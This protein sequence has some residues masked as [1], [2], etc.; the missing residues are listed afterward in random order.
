MEYQDKINLLFIAYIFVIV[1]LF[2][3]QLFIDHI[4]L[5]T[6]KLLQLMIELK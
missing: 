6:I 5:D 4:M 3:L 1:I 2:G